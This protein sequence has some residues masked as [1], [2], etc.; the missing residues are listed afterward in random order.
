MRKLAIFGLFGIS[1]I[2]LLS[3]GIV[4][5]SPSEEAEVKSADFQKRSYPQ[6]SALIFVVQPAAAEE[7]ILADGITEVREITEVVQNE[8]TNRTTKVTAYHTDGEVSHERPLLQRTDRGVTV[9]ELQTLL[10][11]NGA[12]LEVDGIFGDE[13]REAVLDYQEANE[14]AVDG[15]VGAETWGDLLE[16]EETPDQTNDTPEA[17]ADGN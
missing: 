14:L 4:L 13:T 3:M 15:F 9:E 11:E 2:F 16:V 12:E 5:P 7:P 10:N 17:D 8:E 6:A 1:L